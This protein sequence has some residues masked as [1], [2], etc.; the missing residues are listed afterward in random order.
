MTRMRSSE[1]SAALRSV[2]VDGLEGCLDVGERGAHLVAPRL[3]VHPA[4][5][6]AQKAT[7]SGLRITMDLVVLSNRLR[8][9]D[10][11]FNITF[12]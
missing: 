10:L 2:E 3:Q 5:C 9:Y 7:V 12:M 6:S 11:L 1:A 8:L 4:T